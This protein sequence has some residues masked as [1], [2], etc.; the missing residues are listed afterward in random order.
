[1]IAELAE[2]RNAV[3]SIDEICLHLFDQWC[4]S[5]SVTP[6]AYLMHCWPLTDRRAPSVKRLCETLWE[7][8]RQHPDALDGVQSG[9]L[10]ELTE[11]CD[12]MLICTPDGGARNGE[13]RVNRRW[14]ISTASDRT[15]EPGGQT[16]PT[17]QDMASEARSSRARSI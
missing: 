11:R 14:P 4:E 5:R 3:E 2:Y 8:G 15:T 7:L 6:L 9:L 12:D 1:M 16:E 13:R 17:A 10:A